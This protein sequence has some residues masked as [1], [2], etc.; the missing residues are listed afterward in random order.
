MRCSGVLWTAQNIAQ[1]G[2]DERRALMV[3][4]LAGLRD[5]DTPGSSLTHHSTACVST[6]GRNT[7]EYGESSGVLFGVLTDRVRA[8]E[9]VPHHRGAQVRRARREAKM[10]PLPPGPGGCPAR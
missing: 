6:S 9:A 4:D 10:E 2:Y 7:R 3:P 1:S 5:H 8:V